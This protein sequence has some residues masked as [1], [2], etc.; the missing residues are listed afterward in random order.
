MKVAVILAFISAALAA[1]ALRKRDAPAP[2]LKL[3]NQK[4]I[5]GK[6]IVKL[7]E[8]TSEASL[9]RL[10]KA[11]PETEDHVYKTNG[12]KGFAS[13]LSTGS[14]KTIQADFDV[15]A[16]LI[17]YAALRLTFHLRLSLSRKMVL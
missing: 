17:D 10:L 6:Y 15:S 5:A 9:Q 13:A 8:G 11:F 16:L 14:L 7:K 3:V 12:F 2:L 1:P 4:V